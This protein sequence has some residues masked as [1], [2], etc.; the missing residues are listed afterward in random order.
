MDRLTT[1]NTNNSWLEILFYGWLF[2]MVIFIAMKVRGYIDIGWTLAT[3]PI[4]FPLSLYLIAFLYLHI[5]EAV[6]YYLWRR[7][8]ERQEDIF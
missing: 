2:I 6:K 7:K 4:W 1:K 5:K 8:H 3:F